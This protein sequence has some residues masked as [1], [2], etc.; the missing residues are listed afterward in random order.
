MIM[1]KLVFGIC[2]SFCNHSRALAVLEEL[3]AAGYDITAVISENASR[4]DTRF[5]KA[6]EFVS[7]VEE[8]TGKESIRDI[9]S[10]EAKIT[11]KGFVGGIICPCTG[12][13][14]AKLKNGVT[15]TAVTMA[16]K[17][18]LRNDHPLLIA[19]ATN[20]ALGAT[21]MNFAEL[22]NRKCYHF[23]PMSQDDAV[24]KPNSMICDFTRVKEL[25]DTIWG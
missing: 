12:N 3:V 1:S 6:D 22:R 16:A 23:V 7:R 5:G 25:A 8:L 4:Y 20:D 13:T 15:D 21:F 11:G 18:L 19:L 9:A 2:G 14:L 10:A 17:C 24:K